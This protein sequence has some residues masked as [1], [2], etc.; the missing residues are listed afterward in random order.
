VRLESKHLQKPR[1]GKEGETDHGHYKHRP[2]KRRNGGKSI[3]HSG[4]IGLRREQC[5]MTP[6]SRNTE[7]SDVHC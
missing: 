7:I 2:W 1:H 3:G 4:R 5:E 6:E